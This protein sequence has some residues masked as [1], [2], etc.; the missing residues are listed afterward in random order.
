M[1]LACSWRSTVYRCIPSWG[2]GHAATCWGAHGRL[3]LRC[4]SG[5]QNAP[6]QWHQ[7]IQPTWG[8][9][10]TWLSEPSDALTS[11]KG[12]DAATNW[13]KKRLVDSD[14]YSYSVKRANGNITGSNCSVRNKTF[15][16]KATVRQ[17]GELFTGGVHLHL[18]PTV[19]GQPLTSMIKSCVMAMETANVFQPA[20]EIL[21]EVLWD[22]L[23]QE[24]TPSLTNP[25]ELGS[26]SQ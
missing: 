1:L 23:T 20:G 14:G 24:P 15:N 7:S 4:S 17:E 9:R 12:L 11:S 2:F 3:H 8:L 10:H 25:R 13:G 5:R 21:N 22:D 6:F 16:C 19:P 18:N 26:S